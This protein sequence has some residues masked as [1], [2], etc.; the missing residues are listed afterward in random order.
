MLNA[1]S[2]QWNSGGQC[3][4]GGIVKIHPAGPT[5]FKHPGSSSWSLQ[6]IFVNLW[7][8][9]VT[10]SRMESGAPCHHISWSIQW[11]MWIMWFIC[12][13]VLC[14]IFLNSLRPRFSVGDKRKLHQQTKKPAPPGCRCLR[15][16]RQHVI[17]SQ[18]NQSPEWNLAISMFSVADVLMIL[19]S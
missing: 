2:H 14:L 10:F 18:L 9:Q 7:I 5:V 13:H 17:S 12:C 16:L 1:K 19:M 8:C 4:L 11:F 3:A 15:I 6:W